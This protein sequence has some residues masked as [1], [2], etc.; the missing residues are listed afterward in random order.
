MKESLESFG[1]LRVE[2]QV[3]FQLPSGKE[4]VLTITEVALSRLEIELFY[5]FEGISSSHILKCV[6]SFGHLKDIKTR[7]SIHLGRNVN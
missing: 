3:C 5:A 7:K 4:A 1:L 6:R 2:Q